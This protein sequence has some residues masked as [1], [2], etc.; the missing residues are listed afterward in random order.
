MRRAG[1]AYLEAPVSGSK[2]PAEQGQ[3]IFLSA[4]AW[5]RLPGCISGSVSWSLAAQWHH[6]M[7][8]P[9]QVL[10]PRLQAAATCPVT[11]SRRP[12]AV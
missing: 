7:S 11:F 1:G 9:E 6:G 5:W 10:L 4:G 8:F 12:P 2:G 3:L